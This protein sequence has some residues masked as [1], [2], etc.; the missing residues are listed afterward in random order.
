MKDREIWEQLA[1]VMGMILNAEEM[2]AVWVK[3]I[4]LR[5][6]LVESRLA[7]LTENP[8]VSPPGA[9]LIEQ[10]CRLLARQES[11]HERHGALLAELKSMI[12]RLD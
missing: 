4:H 2:Q 5:I 3:N 8:E 9:D 12:Q 6:Q 7:A 10:A 1:G 11:Q